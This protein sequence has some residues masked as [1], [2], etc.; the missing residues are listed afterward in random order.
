MTLFRLDASILPATST[1]R[2]LGDV[3]EEQWL[4]ARPGDEIVRRDVAADPIPATAWAEVVTGSFA[5]EDQQSDA[6]R[7][8]QQLS[9]ELAEELISSDALL[10][11]VPLYNYGVSQHFKTWFDVAHL[12]PRLG[13]TGT[14]LQGKPAVL[15]TA[16]GGNYAP[17]T[18]KE[19]WDHSTGWIR[20]VFEDVWG[21]K[22]HVIQRPFTFVGMDPT[23]DQFAELAAALHTEAL[24]QAEAAGRQIAA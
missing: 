4:K 10:F 19:G 1:T 24:G 17:G 18:P 9:T 11:N 2:A 23:L 8:A 6:F 15:V 3:V 21:L 22:L 13:P 16:L 20:R 7:A 5:P 12:D 14:A